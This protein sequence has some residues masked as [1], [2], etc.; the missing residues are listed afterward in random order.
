MQNHFPSLNI[1]M[2]DATEWAVD[3]CPDAQW[4]TNGWMIAKLCWYFSS[5]L[6][7][8]MKILAEVPDKLVTMN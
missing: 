5:Q 1:F 6:T 7:T 3:G 8:F 2:V 4:Q